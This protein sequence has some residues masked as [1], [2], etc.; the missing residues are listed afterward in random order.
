MDTRAGGEQ[1]SSLLYLSHGPVIY[2]CDSSYRA[3]LPNIE[4]T[5]STT[6][7]PTA[8]PGPF[9]LPRITTLLASLLVALG[10]GT[11]YVRVF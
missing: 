1:I 8:I 11:N 6:Q 10:A 7:N 3:G 2:R 5:M 4:A 9:G